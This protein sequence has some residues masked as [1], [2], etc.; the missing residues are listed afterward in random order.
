MTPNRAPSEQILKMRTTA[1]SAGTIFSIGLTFLCLVYS[2]S[3]GQVLGLRS[4]AGE[5][6]AQ[7][8]LAVAPDGRVFLSWIEPAGEK[9]HA[10][11]FSVLGETSW[12]VSRTISE[13]SN[14]F[15]N[16]ADFPS[17]AV[18]PDSSLAA[19]WLARSG[20]DTYAYDV[21][22]SRSYDGGTT[23]TRP[24]TPHHDSTQTEHGFVSMFPAPDGSLGAAWLD[25]REMT[26]GEE[27][28]GH[29][30]MSLRFASLP[31]AGDP[32]GEAVLDDKVCECCQTSVAITSEGPIV[33]YRDRLDGE[34][35]DISTVR[36]KGGEWTRPRSVSH[37]GW[38]I[39]G[40]PVNGPAIDARGPGVAVAWFTA[41][42]DTPRVKLAFSDD[43]GETFGNPILVD[44]GAPSGR[45]DVALLDDGSAMVSWLERVAGGGEVRARRIGA[46]GRRGPAVTIAPSGT[47]R[48]SGFPRMVRSGKR[49]VFAW[50]GAGVLT[51]TLSL[52]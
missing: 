15:V 40:C 2:V 33:V 4:P 48:S 50:T 1:F 38:K 25:G 31:R 44:D 45:V 36:W 20:P 23:W 7:P 24:F 39:D 21:R 52:P 49:L 19:H 9:R 27:G 35:R 5:G 46:D 22:I 47:A 11:K 18:L 3:S 32:V 41:A 43:A 29:G 8:S 30:N 17:L 10:L 16:W 12:S 26:G 34:I 13:G 42:G 51:A 6:S 28:Y 14:W 37:D